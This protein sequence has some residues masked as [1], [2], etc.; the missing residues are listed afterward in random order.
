M[1]NKK[2]P[3]K[4]TI[5]IVNFKSSVYLE[6]QMKILYEFNDPESFKIII[7]DNSAPHE[8]DELSK[9]AKEYEQYH[10][11]EVIYFDPSSEPW[12]RGSG[13]HGQ[14]LN[15]VLKRADTEYLLVHDPDF[16]F[17]QK[18]FL[19]ALEEK[20]NEGNF[21]IG[22]P[23]RHLN[24]TD[25]GEIGKPD[26]P[27]AFGAAY[28]MS[29]IADLSFLPS[30]SLELF[31]AG[32][33]CWIE[34]LGAD[35]G[36]E[37]RKKLSSAKYISFDQQLAKL[38]KYN[39]GDYSFQQDPYEY[40]LD[41]KRIAYHLFRGTFVDDGRKF[42]TLKIDQTTPEQWNK[43]REKFAKYFYEIAKNDGKVS[44]ILYLRMSFV[45]YVL[46]L[47]AIDEVL[48]K[49]IYLPIQIIGKIINKIL[50]RITHPVTFLKKKIRKSQSK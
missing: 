6:Y 16:F 27:S 26:F 22:A 14:G 34:P 4:W 3:K 50:F 32:H 1:P 46:N 21:S 15:E 28:K 19:A 17:V 29:E 25:T 44:G 37:M 41:G 45:Y 5:G 49:I 33:I 18:N 2:C 35:V 48:D 42:S 8:T 12:M 47:M 20:L 10:N 36:W 9:I 38:L 39:F 13:Q 30:V 23:Y 40:F 11:M 43:T 24:G 7:I 31:K